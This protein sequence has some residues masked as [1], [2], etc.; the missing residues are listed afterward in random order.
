MARTIFIENAQLIFKNFSGKEGPY[1]DKGTRS[2][3]VII[4]D[5]EM[6]DR[7]KNDGWLIKELAP[8]DEDEAPKHYLTI[9]LSYKVAPPSVQML[10]GSNLITMSEETIGEL[11][12]QQII[13][14]DLTITPY[15]W[16]MGSKSGIKAYLKGLV[17]T[18]DEDPLMMKYAGFVTRN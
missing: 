7:L 18:V 9:A 8:R 2:F 4:D 3:A 13:S 10:M 16:E 6:A 12:F 11:D 1:N 5:P 15:H 17:A 14:A